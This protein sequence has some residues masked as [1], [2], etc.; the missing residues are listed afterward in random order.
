MKV[1]GIVGTRRRDSEEDF[2][3]V[4]KEFLKI[5]ERGDVICSGL[6]GKGADRFAVLLSK[7]YNTKTLWFPAD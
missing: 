2:K 4:E 1:I 6:C 3:I 7:K 5:Y